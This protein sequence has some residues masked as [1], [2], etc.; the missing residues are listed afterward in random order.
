MWALLEANVDKK[1]EDRMIN[2]DFIAKYYGMWIDSKPFDIGNAT[3]TALGCLRQENWKLS[4]DAQGPFAYTAKKNALQ[5]ASNRSNG[6]LMR[7]TPM[8]VWASALEPEDLKKA[9]VCDAE[10]THPNKLVQDCVFLYAS[11]IRDLIN[12]P[13]HPMRAK[14]SFDKAVTLSKEK[15]ANFTSDDGESAYKWLIAAFNLA[16]ESFNKPDFDLKKVYDCIKFEGF[17]KHGF[18]LSF[19]YL[20]RLQKLK[21][22]TNFYYNSIREII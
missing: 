4:D 7:C 2:A 17:I 9:I 5:T 21:D 19:Y 16:E 12:N 6:S 20:L 14:M 15:L 13:T 18:I 11:T 3:K 8:A 10:F 22:H 1:P